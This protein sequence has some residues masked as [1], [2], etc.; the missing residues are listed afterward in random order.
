M[1]QSVVLDTIAQWARGVSSADLACLIRYTER[2]ALANLYRGT[3]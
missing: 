3:S 1:P 2:A